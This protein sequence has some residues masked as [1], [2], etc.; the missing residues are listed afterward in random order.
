[1]TEYKVFKLSNY[2]F[3]TKSNEVKNAVT[4]DHA[5]LAINNKED[6]NLH[7]K[8][9]PTLPCILFG[10]IDYTTNET[11]IQT[12]L[13]EISNDLNIPL[14]QFTFTHNQKEEYLTCHWSIPSY[15]T[16]IKTLKSI[17][18]Q[19]KYKSFIHI[20]SNKKEH[21]QCDNSI[22]KT[23]PFR[24]PY[25]SAKG[26]T[27]HKIIKGKSEDF[28]IHLIPTNSQKLIWVPP[29]VNPTVQPKVQ[30]KVEVELFNGDL[31]TENK[32]LNLL[33]HKFK[34]YDD[35]SKMCWILKSL[36]YSYD[37]F[38]EYSKYHPEKYEEKACI[39]QWQNSKVS[40]K[41]TEGILHSMAKI[42]KP[43]EYAEL[44]IT[45]EF[46]KKDKLPSDIEIIEMNREYLIDLDNTEL[47]K[48]ACVISD[49]IKIFNEDQKYKS[50]NVKSPYD[51]GKTQLLKRYIETYDPK[52]ILWVSYRK[53]LTS[54][55]LNNF[56]EY[57]LIDYQTH[58]Y[59][60]D[61]LI[62]QLES[63]HKIL[64]DFVDE[65]EL[66]NYDL[67][68]I[69]EVE[70]VLQQF[71]SNTIDKKS[72]ST[73][74]LLS[75]VIKGS[76]KLITL[77]GDMDLRT[78]KFINEFGPSININNIVKKSKKEFKL[79]FSVNFYQ[80]QIL[81]DLKQKKKLIIASQTSTDC[82]E[83]KAMIEKYDDKLKIGIYTGITSDIDKQD[84][85][86]V[87]E[88]WQQ[89]DVVIYSPT[90]ES[91]VNFDV[92]NYFDKIYCVVCAG[93]NSQRG[94]L[95]MISRARKL[96]EN[97]VL[98]YCKNLKYY[99]VHINSFYSFNEINES[100]TALNIIE[101]S[102]TYDNG[103]I[104]KSLT[105]YDINYIYNK[106]EELMKDSPIFYLNYLKR[107]IEIKGHSVEIYNDKVEKEKNNHK[108]DK[109]EGMLEIKDICDNEF[110]YLMTKQKQSIA[111]TKDKQ[112]I[113]KHFLKKSYGVDILDE[114][115]M[116]A[117]PNPTVITNFEHLIDIKNIRAVDSNK[118]KEDILKT[119]IINDVISELGFEIFNDKISC[120]KDEFE[121]K[122]TNLI[123]NNELFK[124]SNLRTL[125]TTLNFKT[126]KTTRDFMKFVNE[127]LSNYGLIIKS[128][129]RRSK[130]SEGKLNAR[131]SCYS[132]EFIN[133]SINEIIQYKINKGYQL[134]DSNNIR[135]NV[136]SFIYS[137]LI[138]DPEDF[139]SND[140]DECDDECDEV[141]NP[142][143]VL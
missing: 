85:E 120:H 62:I 109:V 41:M 80:T 21:S 132:L 138:K 44:N 70:S 111:T 9:N 143:D 14:T 119:K 106:K 40:Q 61:R 94:F 133:K 99:D 116:E 64:P 122:M 67:V 10:D 43:I 33:I 60:S 92:L 48:K 26:K 20:D 1:M 59:D 68:I 141:V 137:H 4:L 91:G 31:K 50:F 125:F 8:I 107:L 47:N 52:R 97:D 15:Y 123:N 127:V 38:H 128:V 51:T 23:I 100:L 131:E 140:D 13:E 3:N 79:T 83:L 95:Q 96:K 87:I 27:I 114:S 88:N 30:P 73:F 136:E 110:E 104:T 39:K 16:D 102:I 129:S 108:I 24:L 82:D 113:K 74:Q 34:N 32:L 18:S 55:I 77:D 115:I 22:Y 49:Q 56:K 126:L 93:C 101:K 142:L 17:F 89:L 5:I 7:L 53:T 28:I 66:P 69:D 90:I 36:N 134:Y 19:D 6:Q 117:Y 76:K 75:E 2:K 54:D 45:T 81:E 11:E 112:K 58:K 57:G 130:K 65:S 63:L 86:N 135:P 105:P 84:L 35:W 12:I 71:N 98:V 42:D 118:H 124:N 121:V 72:K 25:Q 139:E 37:V 103:K 46:Y 78:Y 29:K